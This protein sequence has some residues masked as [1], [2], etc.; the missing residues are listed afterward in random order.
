MIK[1]TY[2]RSR[3]LALRS[4]DIRI[5]SRN[6]RAYGERLQNDAYAYASE[7]QDAGAPRR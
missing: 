2:G 1:L 5:L 7:Y 3:P 6:E 4:V